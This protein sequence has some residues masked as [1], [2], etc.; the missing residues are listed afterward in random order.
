MPDNLPLAEEK[1]DGNK[2]IAELDA[3]K[4]KAAELLQQVK[5]LNQ[6]I[7]FNDAEYSRA[8]LN[9][10]NPKYKTAVRDLEKALLDAKTTESLDDVCD[11]SAYLLTLN[12]N[13]ETIVQD[14]KKHMA[15]FSNGEI[16]L[17][18]PSITSQFISAASNAAS[19]GMAGNIVQQLA[20]RSNVVSGLLTSTASAAKEVATVAIAAKMDYFMLALKVGGAF[21]VAASAIYV[22][23]RF[24]EPL[25]AQVSRLGIFNASGYTP[26]A[27]DA[28]YPEAE[29]YHT[30]TTERSTN[31]SPC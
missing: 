18:A 5:N 9:T 21:T 1:F 27:C 8:F 2:F 30:F 16:N 24:R 12:S 31:A 29:D 19:A 25:I 7:D 14:I 6:A 3:R 26:L 28:S 13:L 17:A 10:L 11:K 4:I 22:I 20:G 15:A 23:L